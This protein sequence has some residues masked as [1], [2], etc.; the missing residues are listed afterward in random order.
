MQTE[1]LKFPHVSVTDPKAV[2]SVGVG[3][4]ASAHWDGRTSLLLLKSTSESRVFK[5]P[6]EMDWMGANP[7]HSEWCCAD[8]D[9]SSSSLFAGIFSKVQG[10]WDESAEPLPNL[11]VISFDKMETECCWHKRPFHTHQQTPWTRRTN[12][13]LPIVSKSKVLKYTFQKD[14][15]NFILILNVQ[16]CE[17][18]TIQPC[19]FSFWGLDELQL[20]VEVNEIPTAARPSSLVTHGPINSA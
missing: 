7:L 6:V 13:V 11:A 4:D 1:T 3:S 14:P 8:A 20:P 9:E 17:E 15:K 2:C 10:W 19:P 16:I 5:G 12:T 18:H